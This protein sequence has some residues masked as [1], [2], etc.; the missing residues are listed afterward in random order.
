VEEFPTITFKSTRVEPKG[1]DHARV[2]GDLT[3][4]G[5]TREVE[6]DTEINGVGKN[7]YGQE[8]VGFS[9]ETSISRKEWGL[10]WNVALESGG[11]LVAD[12]LKITIEGQATKQE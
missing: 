1:K 10:T 4:R 8:V 7:P 9:A 12:R 5:T 3:V 11:W 2:Y 6:L